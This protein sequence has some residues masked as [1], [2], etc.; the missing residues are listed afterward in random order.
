M[1]VNRGP[2]ST[3]KVAL[4]N[5]SAVPMLRPTADSAVP[6]SRVTPTKNNA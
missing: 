5:A 2:S 3:G 6:M 4:E 1:R